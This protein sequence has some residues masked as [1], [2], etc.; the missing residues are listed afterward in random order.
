MQDPG[1][2]QLEVGIVEHC[3]ERGEL[4]RGE[5]CR[6]NP[7]FLTEHLPERGHSDGIEHELHLRVDGALRGGIHVPEATN[8]VCGT[9]GVGRNPPLGYMNGGMV[10]PS[11]NTMATRGNIKVVIAD[12]HLS[13]GEALQVALD[14]ERDLVV[15]GVVTDGAAAFDAALAEEPD[16][17]LVDL[18]MPGVDGIEVAKRLR[19]ADASPAVVLLTSDDD[20][21]AL[22]RAVQAGARGLVAKTE[23][24]EAFA[25]AVRRAHRGD[26][27]HASSDVEDS[28]RRL[29]KQRARDG[30]LSDRL[31]RLTPRELQILQLMADGFTP[32]E[33][34]ADLG[35][36]RHTLRTHT[37]NVLTKLGVHTK[38]DAIVAAIR[39][40]KV[41]TIDVSREEDLEPKNVG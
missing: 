12:D 19:Q 13:F 17:V 4:G 1:E 6:W 40:G 34:S 21:L 31:D 38:L 7:R 22:A 23:P 14:L 11:I 24:V 8:A 16:V 26:P 41:T 37:Q 32:E 27:L 29:R 2:V 15:I 30:H 5:E 20:N 18:D 25:D 35:M 39:F 36:S 33:L 3:R 28:F 9:S 10:G